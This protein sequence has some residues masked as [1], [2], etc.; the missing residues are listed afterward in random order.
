MT[1]SK[2][3]VTIHTRLETAAERDAVAD[4]GFVPGWASTLDRLAEL[5]PTA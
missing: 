4:A 3:A 1:Q 2:S 5:L